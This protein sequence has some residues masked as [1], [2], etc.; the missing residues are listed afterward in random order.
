MI[1]LGVNTVLFQGHDLATA[2]KHIAW[3]GYDGVELSAIKG[4]CEHLELDKW[5]EQAESI[6]AMA[7]EYKLKLLSMEVASQNEERLTKA[8][9]AAQALG[10]PVINIGP[11]GKSN[12]EEDFVR[13]SAVIAKLADK[14][15]TYG[16]TLCVKAHVNQVVYNT[17][18]TL[19]LM[20]AVKSPGFGVDMDPSHIYRSA[21]APEK[22]LPAVLPRMKHIHIR[23]CKGRGPSP[24][25]PALQA[26][27][28]GDIDLLGYFK[29]MVDAKYNGPVCLEVIG[30]KG[31]EVSKQAIIA[32]ESYGYMNACLKALG[33]R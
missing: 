10:V 3:A 9:E 17:P 18:T 31:Y 32:A 28:R 30:A 29:A 11:G 26:C 16:V 2:M 14:A 20:E 1:Q 21:E 27:G 25:E 22:A 24:G 5:R 7:A 4:M 12:V 19:R 15:H 8:F 13:Q 23:D 33:A 6:K